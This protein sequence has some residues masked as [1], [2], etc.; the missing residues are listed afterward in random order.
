MAG[1]IV[2]TPTGETRLR[3]WEIHIEALDDLGISKVLDCDA[4]K[5]SDVE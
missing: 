5:S 2:S 4:I 3:L 1:G